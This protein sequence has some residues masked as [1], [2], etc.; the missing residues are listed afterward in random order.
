MMQSVVSTAVDLNL[1]RLRS[2]VGDEPEV[3]SELVA[4]WHQTTLDAL[5]ELRGAVEIKDSDGVVRSAHAIKGASGNVGAESAMELASQI[6]RVARRGDLSLAGVLL[7][8]LERSVERAWA[9]RP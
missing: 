9:S 4:L 1:D 8:S 6:E 3:L 5:E 7:A 2:F